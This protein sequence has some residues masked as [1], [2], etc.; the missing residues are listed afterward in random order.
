MKIT[1]KHADHKVTGKG[2]SINGTVGYA[3]PA[4]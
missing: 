2:R 4:T 1:V 3:C